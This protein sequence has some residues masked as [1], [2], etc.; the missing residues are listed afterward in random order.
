MMHDDAICCNTAQNPWEWKLQGSCDRTETRY[1]NGRDSIPFSQSK[2]WVFWS[3]TQRQRTQNAWANW[4]RKKLWMG[5]DFKVNTAMCVTYL[6]YIYIKSYLSTSYLSSAWLLN[7]SHILQEPTYPASGNSKGFAPGCDLCSS[8]GT[9][10]WTDAMDFEDSMGAIKTTGRFFLNC[11]CKWCWWLPFGKFTSCH[12]VHVP[13]F[14]LEKNVQTENLL[15][16]EHPNRLC[17]FS[18]WENVL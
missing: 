8:F 9:S 7:T 14:F 16:S 1:C 2:H 5:C 17:R 6:L 13:L 3:N 12:W 4:W 15:T 10:T 11:T 18:L